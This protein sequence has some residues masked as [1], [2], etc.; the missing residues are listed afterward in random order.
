MGWMGWMGLILHTVT[1]E[2]C[3]HTYC[4]GE[5]ADGFLVAATLFENNFNISEGVFGRTQ[6][7]LERVIVLTQS[8]TV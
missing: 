6:T 3:I 7:C 2:A 4:I 5:F 1:V 8:V